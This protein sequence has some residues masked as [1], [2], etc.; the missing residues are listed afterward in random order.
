MRKKVNADADLVSA[1][2]KIESLGYSSYGLK[3]GEK[4][5]LKP[6]SAKTESNLPKIF[7]MLEVLPKD[8]YIVYC[9]NPGSKGAGVEFPITTNIIGENM[10]PPSQPHSTD[11]ASA[12]RLGRLESENEYLRKCE[13]EL[14][15]ELRI[16]L[17]RIA[18]LESQD[19]A[20]GEDEPLEENQPTSL[21]DAFAPVLPGLLDRGLSL[22]ES[23]LS[24]KKQPTQ[25]SEQKPE[26]DY[27]K[28]AD[29]VTQN[30][31]SYQNEQQQSN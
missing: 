25:L 22:M 21:M 14:K 3:Q 15:E 29:I 31:I 28:L 1:K 30:I 27:H 2:R 16:A 19:F 13:A 5:L 10:V 11:V 26:I 6:N 4:W 17:N 18:E 24:S 7:K 12:E 8:I 9:T 23:Y 20:E